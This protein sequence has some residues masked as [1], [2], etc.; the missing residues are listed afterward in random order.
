MTRHEEN[1]FD[2][3][4]I[5]A[6]YL[7]L[8]SHSWPL[9]GKKPEFW[10]NLTGYETG[11]GLA[12]AIFFFTSGYVMCGSLSRRADFYHFALSRCLRILPGLS[13]VVVIS[14]LVIGPLFTKL[15]LLSY[16]STRETWTYFGNALVFPIQFQL[17]GVFEGTPHG[18]TING[19]LWTL[20]IEVTMYGLL[21]LAFRIGVIIKKYAIWLPAAFFL[22]L[23]SRTNIL[24]LGMGKSRG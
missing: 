5:A 11:G 7:V 22:Q 3:I 17:P 18:P 13:V 10:A 2:F 15:P 12:V 23:G 20:P 24:G 6:A 9:F 8:I 16:F 19:S 21:F 4:R 14:V 1:N